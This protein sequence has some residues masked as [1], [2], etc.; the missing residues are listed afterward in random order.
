[1]CHFCRSGTEK[2]YGEK[3]QLLQEILDVAKG[4]GYCI[5]PGAA[6]KAAGCS[7]A[8]FCQAS[9]PAA[10]T[11]SVGRAKRR[12]AM[13]VRDSAFVAI[14]DDAADDA[15]TT[16]GR[17]PCLWV[18]DVF[19]SV[20]TSTS[21]PE[22]PHEVLA[23]LP[24][25]TRRSAALSKLQRAARGKQSVLVRPQVQQGHAEEGGELLTTTLNFREASRLGGRNA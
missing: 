12:F 2:Q 22:E 21:A 5:R 23:P 17:E 11:G 13:A 15:A 1:M 9:W 18:T 14:R 19:V 16:G 3:K 10:A 24:H 6:R 8:L 7:S 20:E 4:H 25:R